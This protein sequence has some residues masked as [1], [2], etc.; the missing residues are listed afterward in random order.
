MNMAE[1]LARNAQRFPTKPAVMDQHRTITHQDFHLRTNRLANYLLKQRLSR[2]D[3]VAL[4]CGNRVEH[5]ETIF[6]VAKIGAIAVPFD[7]NWKIHEYDAMIKFFEP[8]A[9]IVEEREETKHALDLITERLRPNH[10]LSIGA[11]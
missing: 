2:G 9:F 5:L 4:A 10:V 7:Y 6:A 3:C 1:A 8:S 11:N